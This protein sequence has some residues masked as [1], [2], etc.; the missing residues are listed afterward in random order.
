[1]EAIALI[2]VRRKMRLRI[3]HKFC[4]KA[5]HDLQYGRLKLI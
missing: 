1:M 5:I 2:A 3:T 4:T